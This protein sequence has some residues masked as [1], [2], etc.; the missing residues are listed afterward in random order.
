LLGWQ[1]L[2][3]L[4]PGTDYTFVAQLEDNQGRLWAKADALGY[5]P[6]D[7]QPGVQALQLL[8]FRLPGDLP[9]RT[10]RLTLAVVDRQTGQPLPADGGQTVIPLT[11]V[12]GRLDEHPQAIALERLPNPIREEPGASSSRAGSPLMLRGY[13]LD[14]VGD[15]LSL[16]LHWEVLQQ[17]QQDYQLH[18]FL[19]DE[20]DEPV[21]IYRWPPVSP[22]GG[23]WPTSHWPA[24]YWIQD[25][26]ELAVNSDIPAGRY[27]LWVSLTPSE[28]TSSS[29]SQLA[30][31]LDWIDIGQ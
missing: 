1:A 19:T 17:P 14:P 27:K 20:P 5:S 12:T 9:V 11:S 8:T 23:E 31:E 13:R 29:S 22:I 18:F 26:L 28:A 21:P 16:T 7:W 6:A 24:G 4:P 15:Q 2:R 3:S 10:Y 30:I 25:R